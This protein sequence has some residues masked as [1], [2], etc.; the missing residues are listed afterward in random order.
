M[1]TS[2]ANRR[3]DPPGA[4]A[5]KEEKSPLT[6]YHCGLEADE[7]ASVKTLINGVE[8]VFCC[9]GCASVC[10][11][12]YN[13][14]LE[15]FYT[16]KPAG[17]FKPPPSARADGDAYDTPEA[18]EEFVTSSGEHDEARLLV[19]GLHCAACVWLVEKAAAGVDGVVSAE[20]NLARRS[21]KIQWKKDKPA[22][23]AMIKTLDRFGYKAVPYDL[24]EAG[25]SAAR[26]RRDLMLRMGFAGFA[27]MNMM[28]ISIALWTGAAGGE[29]SAFFRWLGFAIA[30]PVLAYS[31]YPFLIGAW[32][33][34]R[35]GALNMDFPI[36]LA[37]I[38]TYA[39]SIYV[40]LMK[41]PGAEVYFD[42][43][44]VF[45]FALLV[46]RFLESA[47]REKAAEATNR[48][49]ELQPKTAIVMRDG[50]EVSVTARSISPG[51]L[52][53][54]K[55]GDRAPVDGVIEKGE[56]MVD[57]SALT[58]ESRHVFKKG[59][60]DIPAGAASV[61]GAFLA[62][63]SRP[64]SKSAIARMAQMIEDAQA[65]KPPIQ[66]TADK[67]VPWFV[68]GVLSLA[69]ITFAIWAGAGIEKAMLN[70]VTAL[71]I[72]C[73]CALGLATPMVIA[74]AIGRGAKEGLLIRNGA[75]LETLAKVK[76]IVFD[77]TGV[78]TSGRMKV[79]SI[80]SEN[81][82]DAKELL[83]L[84]APVEKM[85]KHAL[86]RAILQ[87]ADERGIDIS[88]ACV[89]EFKNEAGYG[90]TAKVDGCDVS[91]TS[92]EWLRKIGVN[93]PPDYEEEGQAAS[94]RGLTEV[95]VLVNG[96]V[97]GAIALE[98]TPR[99]EANEVLSRLYEMGIP[100]FMLT[101]DNEK[102][103]SEI[104]SQLG[105]LKYYANMKP[106]DKYR[107]IE[108]LQKNGDVVAM[109]GDGINDAPSLALAD[110]G[111]AMGEGVDIAADN[112]DIVI[113]HGGLSKTLDAVSLSKNVMRV[114]QQNIA[115]SIFYN[116]IAA[117]L[118]LMGV[119]TPLVA[120]VAMPA[121]SLAVVAN[122]ARLGRGS[123]PWR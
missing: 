29:Y 71:I 40:T 110:V 20:V 57:L 59:G 65:R 9:Q 85:S 118:A 94:E 43:V 36:S 95:F 66:R 54:I 122:A 11:A 106:E 62:R 93:P 119:V 82:F 100:G 1:T 19:D 73:P 16:K 103:A 64:A 52:V 55:P 99:Q 53:A 97:A 56:G 35:A 120:A 30:T 3:S 5:K 112:A 24:E 14:G 80:K 18:R 34:I 88:Q 27:A 107:A 79:V 75:A 2:S 74:V 116:V 68:I 109:V 47:S 21:M 17:A 70:A 91:V 13:A 12:I 81:G 77:K 60:D 50:V 8:Q 111:M 6:C 78:L 15:K 76:K 22:L 33:G 51:D 115:L 63:A 45:I 23:G 113:T 38:I 114:V 98:D 72:T 25:R 121:S 108:N 4:K 117:T 96:K 58:G 44:V 49:V 39:F 86:G 67:V 37:A 32:R 7:A 105:G 89:T 69:V 92:V 46:G 104:S 61:D 90:V 123:I 83:R 101:G 10:E 41:P 31:G 42:T 84:A 48:L 87:E 26:R 28:W 102:A